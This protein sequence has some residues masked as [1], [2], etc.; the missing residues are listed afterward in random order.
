M[1]YGGINEIVSRWK[2]NAEISRGSDRYMKII[3][4]N[5]EEQCILL[6]SKLDKN[7]K[8]AELLR[9]ARLVRLNDWQTAG[10]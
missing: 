6:D 9:S 5:K 3:L 10:K 8:P 2:N 7:E 4:S 1:I